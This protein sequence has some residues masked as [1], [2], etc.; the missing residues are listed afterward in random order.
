MAF[1]EGTGGGSGPSGDVRQYVAQITRAGEYVPG[2]L[3]Q[4]L[5]QAGVI[6]QTSALG[7]V[8]GKIANATGVPQLAQGALWSV[9]NPRARLTSGNSMEVPWVAGRPW[10]HGSSH[11]FDNIDLTKSKPDSLYGP[12]FYITDDP[13]IASTYASARNTGEHVGT[14]TVRR[15]PGQ[16]LKDTVASKKAEMAQR[17]DVPGDVRRS[18]SNVVIEFQEQ[19]YGPNVTRFGFEPDKILDVRAPLEGTDVKRVAKAMLDSDLSAKEL[20]TLGSSFNR[21]VAMGAAKN[22]LWQEMAG[23]IG[24]ARTNQILAKAG[25]DAIAYPGGKVTGGRP[26]NALAVINSDA[27]KRGGRPNNRFL[28]APRPTR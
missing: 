20:E 10:F 4:Q 9:M 17:G 7:K 14:Y 22:G 26:H 25:Y 27:L 23:V 8:I 19:G 6:G 28:G 18:G 21:L 11:F 2:Y 16:R 13:K 3:R 5:A 1:I 24:P 12:G 15:V